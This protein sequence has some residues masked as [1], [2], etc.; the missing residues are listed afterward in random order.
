MSSMR[1]F[2]QI[3]L[4]I[5]FFV[6]AFA[7]VAREENRDNKWASIPWPVY[8]G[9]LAVGIAGVAVLRSSRASRAAGSAADDGRWESIQSGSADLVRRMAVLFAARHAID[10]YEV[11]TFIDDELAEPLARF[12]NAR[13]AIADRFGLADYARLMTEFASGERAVNR[14][15]SASADGYIDEVWMSLGTARE[16]FERLAALVDAILPLKSPQAT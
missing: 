11:R 5:G 12:A 10:V 14:A 2:G 3:L 1:V 9:G 4:W 13:Q 8:A 6:A 16:R 7:A 15:W